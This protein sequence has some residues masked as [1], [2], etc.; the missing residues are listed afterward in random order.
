M[1]LFIMVGGLVQV[2]VIENLGQRVTDAVGDRYFL[3]ASVLLWGSALL[4]GI[5]DNI[6][7]VAAISPLVQGLVESGG[8]TGEATALWWAVALG[9]GL[10]GNATAVG[11]SAN[12]V[13]LGIAARS[14]HPISFWQFTKYGLVVALVTWSRLPGPTLWLRHYAF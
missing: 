14:G 5:V 13:V 6:P 4:S 7:Y 3:A 8:G 10:G 11:A 2:G 12:V 9:A 1:G